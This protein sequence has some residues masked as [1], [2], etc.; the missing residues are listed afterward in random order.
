MTHKSYA[1][2]R[3]QVASHNER[4]EF[5]GDAI[6]NFLGAE[7]LYQLLPNQPEG[8]LSQLRSRLVDKTQLAEFAIALNLGQR[9]RLGR[10]VENSGGRTNP[11]LLSSAF[12]A[13]IGAYFLDCNA[14]IEAV[15]AYVRPLFISALTQRGTTVTNVKSQFQQ[16]A[17]AE[18]G[19]VPQYQILAATGPDHD[20]H[21]VAQ[22]QVN[23][24]AYGQG[25]GRTKQEAEK[26]A[27]RN[28]LSRLGF[29]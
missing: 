26:Q 18:I 7:L 21:F 29:S 4:L 2:E 5:L 22:V 1:H 24:V 3:G 20:R 15:Q 12:E 8:E 14:Q 27:A 6:L 28:A 16:W 13:L 17:L 10:G 11:R 25:D 9:L 23:G 19:Q